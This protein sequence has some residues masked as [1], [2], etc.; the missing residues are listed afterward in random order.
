MFFRFY[1]H[2]L[3]RPAL[4]RL[5]VGVLWRV[6]CVGLL[7]G[8]M[9]EAVSAILGVMT[10]LGPGGDASYQRL[11]PGLPTWWIPESLWGIGLYLFLMLAAYM[12]NELAREL[13]RLKN[14]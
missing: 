6:G 10:S 1:E 11:V 4:L 7:A 3:N 13:R 12:L 5:I 9:T 8:A 2:L 14:Y